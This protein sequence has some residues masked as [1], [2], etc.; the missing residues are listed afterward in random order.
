LRSGG[1]DLVLSTNTELRL[2]TGITVDV[3]NALSLARR[4]ADS[5]EQAPA[6]RMHLELLSK[7]ILPD[8]YDD[9]VILERE[10]FR[11]LRLHALEAL[12]VRCTAE[13]RFELAIES[14]L[15]AVAQEP[16]RE[17]AHRELIK[18]HL[19]EGNRAEALRQFQSLRDLLQT[20]LGV[21][22]SDD[23]AQLVR[24]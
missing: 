17:S 21:E 9:W 15:A 1:I 22:P 13:R 20:D 12:C 16:L 3:D 14:G 2:V 4:L 18:A 24:V 11:H 6:E 7:D 10:R 8:W 19:A 5:S 23:L